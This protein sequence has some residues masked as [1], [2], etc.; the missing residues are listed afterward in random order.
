MADAIGQLGLDV[1]QFEK[2]I[3]DANRHLDRLSIEAKKANESIGLFGSAM[4]KLS[5]LFAVGAVTGY[6][7]SIVDMGGAL[8]DQ[9]VALDISAKSIQELNYAFSQSGA[10]ANDVT[11]SLIKL[12]QSIADAKMDT[13]SAREAF[14][15]LGISWQEI[16]N[17]SP[18][19][20][21]MLI[22]EGAKNAGNSTDALNA[23]VDLLGKSGKK[24]AAGLKEGAEG[25]AALRKEAVTLTDKQVKDIDAVGDAWG[26][27]TNAVKAYGAS[28]LL[29]L[30]RQIKNGPDNWRSNAPIPGST[31]TPE[32]LAKMFGDATPE[33]LKE[34]GGTPDPRDVKAEQQREEQANNRAWARREEAIKEND[35]IKSDLEKEQRR[36]LAEEAQEAIRRNAQ[37]AERNRELTD[38]QA[39]DSVALSG[40]QTMAKGEQTR[41]SYAEKI[42]REQANGNIE[43]EEMLKQQRE[44]ELADLAGEEADKTPA[45]RRAERAA[46]RERLASRRRG[47][48]YNA[49]TDRRIEAGA[50][51]DKN[52]RI[53]Q[54]RAEK[55]RINAGEAAIE[56]PEAGGAGDKSGYGE[57]DRTYLKDI[58]KALTARDA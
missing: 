35:R 14:E 38:E 28:L 40:N 50:R 39:V 12:N 57:T 7:R 43:G 53:E 9:S 44:N 47:A 13:G 16:A 33:H 20:I 10:K 17:S 19:E 54:R 3:A 6:I 32:E 8:R 26:R 23:I 1:K 22:A 36:A 48:N 5:G 11:N 56:A 55:A 15:A 37:N 24:M 21:L 25:I 30:G 18:E 41:R 34:G 29:N 2:S 42:R 58:A 52:S 31:R 46:G 51:G 49:E 4:S 27:A 45:M